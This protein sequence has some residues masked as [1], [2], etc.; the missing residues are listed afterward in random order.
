MSYYGFAFL[1]CFFILLFCGLLVP[2]RYS[3]KSLEQNPFQY[4]TPLN[5]K[6]TPY[7]TV[8][9]FDLHD[10]LFK[11][12]EFVIFL[13]VLK[14]ISKG[15]IFYAFNPYF[16]KKFFDLY[17]RNLIW[18]DIFNNL[19]KYYPAL[20]YYKKDFIDIANTNTPIDSMINILDQLKL[21]GYKL[22]LL[23]NIGPETY[24]F[25]FDRHREIMTY[26]DGVYI[27]SSH[28]NFLHKPQPEFYKLFLNYLDKQ[29]ISRQM[30]FIDDIE[31]NLKE[32]LK[33]DIAGIHFTS[34]EKFRNILKELDIL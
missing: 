14:L 5:E 25:H 26:F 31:E 24:S 17:S 11:K 22:Y 16:I 10:V 3:K 2:I 7:N 20:S 27:P 30:L 12:K 28:N 34:F 23:S 19:V 21:K 4:L 8:I 18:E 1:F 29:G 33:F 13:R 9:I 32:A 15:F 6:I